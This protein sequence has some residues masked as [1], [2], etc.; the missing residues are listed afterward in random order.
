VTDLVSLGLDPQVMLAALYRAR[1]NATLEVQYQDAGQM[2]S[3]RYKSDRELAAAIS[4][5]EAKVRGG[6]SVSIVNIRSE[7]GFL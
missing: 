6:S 3:V 4:A 5:I 2:R 7:K 1:A